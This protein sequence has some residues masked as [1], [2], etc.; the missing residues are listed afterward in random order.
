MRAITLGLAVAVLALGLPATGVITHEVGWAL[1][2]IAVALIMASALPSRVLER[3]RERVPWLQTDADRTRS[4]VRELSALLSEGNKLS[5]ELPANGESLEAALDA[6]DDWAERVG[7]TLNKY[8]AGWSA[9]FFDESF[10]G[11]Q[12]GDGTPRSNAQNWYRRRLVKLNDAIGKI[13]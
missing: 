1:T 13:A 10:T 2:A 12:Y 8:R 11:T 9:V 3:I 4:V 6:A 7:V 5:R